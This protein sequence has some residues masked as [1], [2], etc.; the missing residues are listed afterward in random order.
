VTD[1]LTGAK[2]VLQD[3]DVDLIERLKKGH[4]VDPNY[5]PYQVGR[6]YCI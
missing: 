5:D 2:V 3:S 1:P 4:Y 6:S